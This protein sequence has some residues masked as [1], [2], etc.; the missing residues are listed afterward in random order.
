MLRRPDKSQLRQLAKAAKK[1]ISRKPPPPKRGL[2]GK[3]IRGEDVTLGGHRFDG[4]HV[5]MGLIL[6]VMIIGLALWWAQNRAFYTEFTT[7]KVV[8]AGNS[9]DVTRFMGIDSDSSPLK[10]R[11]CFLLET[12]VLA[13]RAEDPVPLVAPNWFKCFKAQ[14]IA[15]DLA[16]GTAVAYLAEHNQPPGFDRI[17]AVSSGGRA[18]M[19]RQPNGLLGQ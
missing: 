15:E 1:E 11:A 16:E 4:R 7:D 13:P 6:S 19:W 10:L 8:I 14:Y 2:G 5:V 18:F 17:V 12:R 9:Y 3:L